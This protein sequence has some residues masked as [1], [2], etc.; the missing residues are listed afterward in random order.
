MIPVP[1]PPAT[2]AVEASAR[3]L[4]RTMLRTVGDHDLIADGDRILV[5]MSGGKDS[6]ALLDLLLRARR[7]S[8][9]RYE[10]VAVHVDQ[11]Q[12]GYDGARLEAYLRG[13][14]VPWEIVREDTYTVVV[15]NTEPGASYCRVCSRLRR[16][17]LYTT[18]ERL[19]CN[20]VALGHHREDVAKPPVR[21]WPVGPSLICYDSSARPLRILR[22]ARAERDWERLI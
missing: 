17:I 3:R 11:G 10:L 21:F 8:P 9:V 12:P 13:L 20:K 7:R 18:A 4:S 16:G 6:H 1:R 19:G 5:A 15:D 2:D 22:I 14:D